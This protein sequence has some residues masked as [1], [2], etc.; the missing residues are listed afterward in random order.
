MGVRPIK[1]WVSG[2]HSW[3]RTAKTGWQNCFGSW[4]VKCV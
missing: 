2:L 4:L 3:Q 1:A